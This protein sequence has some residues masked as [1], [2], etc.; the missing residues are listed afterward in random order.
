MMGQGEIETELL[1]FLR[2][3]IFAPET[4]LTP[5]TNLIAAGFDSMSLVRLLLFIETHY[6]LWIPESEITNATLLNVRAL[7]ATVARLLHEK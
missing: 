4:N 1:A 6:G 7:A 2:R 5:E 3:E